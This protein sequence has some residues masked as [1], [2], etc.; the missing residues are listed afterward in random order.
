MKDTVFHQKTGM[1]LFFLFS[2]ENSLWSL[3]FAL[4]GHTFLNPYL[5]GWLQLT[6]AVVH[7]PFLTE[8]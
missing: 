3:S 6:V 4:A 5:L 1:P 2:K 8:L 7:S